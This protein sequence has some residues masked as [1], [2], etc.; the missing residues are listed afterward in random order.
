MSHENEVPKLKGLTEVGK[1]DLS[2]IKDFRK[3]DK[4]QEIPTQKVPSQEVKKVKKQHFNDGEDKLTKKVLVAKIGYRFDLFWK[5]E[6]VSRKE[7]KAWATKILRLKTSDE[8]FDLQK[9]DFT[10]L[11]AL[12]LALKT[13]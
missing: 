2:Q 8:D 10:Q 5:D 12:V 1:I 6:I 4:K 11:S 13:L 9:L 7:M 3:K